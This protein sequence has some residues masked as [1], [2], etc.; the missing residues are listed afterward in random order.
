MTDSK[1]AKEARRFDAERLNNLVQTAAIIA[2]GAWGVYTF[3][4][5][6]RIKPGLEP[7]AVS[8]TATLVMAGERDDHVAIRSTVMRKNVGQAGVRVLGLTYNVI[9]V[10]ARFGEDS[11]PAGTTGRGNRVTDTTGYRLDEPGTVLLRQ[12]TLFAGA[13]DDDSSPSDLAPGEAVSRDLI[14]Y[15][16]RRQ[17]DLVRFEVSLVYEKADDPAVKLRFDEA[18]HGRLALVPQV[19]CHADPEPCQPLKTTDFGV[20]FSLW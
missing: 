10:R 9:G 16:D 6:A 19:D 11:K 8:V 14:V 3:I 15:V 5:E 1:P 7:P 12:G 20:E 18:A 17:S 2:A 4:Y 13:T